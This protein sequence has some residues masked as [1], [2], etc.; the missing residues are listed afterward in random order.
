MIHSEMYKIALIIP[1]FGE[2]PVWMDLLEAWL[3]SVKGKYS[4]EWIYII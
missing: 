1:Y 3:L 4:N 2:F